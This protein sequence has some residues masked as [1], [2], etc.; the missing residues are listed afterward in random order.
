MEVFETIII[1][2]VILLT[3]LITTGVVKAVC[4]IRKGN[5]ALAT[6]DQSVAARTARAGS[7]DSGLTARDLPPA[8]GDL[9]HVGVIVLSPTDPTLSPPPNY[10]ALPTVCGS[11]ST[12]SLV[13]E[14]AAAAICVDIGTRSL[15]Q[16]DRQAIEGHVSAS[17]LLVD[18]PEQPVELCIEQLPAYESLTDSG[19]VNAW[20]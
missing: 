6:S 4:G 15:E 16:S 20:I 3:A 11:Q 14:Q 9:C 8:Y 5:Q 13:P 19:A 1:V 18:R 7:I 12:V 17:V 10:D 2:A